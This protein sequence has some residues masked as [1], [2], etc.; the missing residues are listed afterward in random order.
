MDFELVQG[1]NFQHSIAMVKI[2]NVEIIRKTRLIGLVLRLN[3]Y[4]YL[5]FSCNL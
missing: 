2:Y 3:W 4:W 1:G 5:E